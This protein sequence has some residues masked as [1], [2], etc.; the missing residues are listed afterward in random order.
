MKRSTTFTSVL[1]SAF[2]FCVFSFST[3]AQH[4]SVH[5]KIS[6]QSKPAKR[7]IVK[8][9]KSNQLLSNVQANKS[10]EYDLEL[11]TGEMYTLVFCADQKISKV[12]Q[13]DARAKRNKILKKVDL[14]FNVTL[15]PDKYRVLENSH[16]HELDFPFAIL[17]YPEKGKNF[18]YSVE[19]SNQ[20]KAI[21]KEV[22]QKNNLSYVH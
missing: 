21:E 17:R 19:Y 22:I 4:I 9:Y 15:I 8:I 11:S 16:V 7:A 2:I 12:I 1:F 5:G 18:K 20:M 14:E 6:A 3:S 13:V 10:G